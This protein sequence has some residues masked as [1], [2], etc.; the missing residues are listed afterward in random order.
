MVKLPGRKWNSKKL[1][2]RAASQNPGGCYY[3]LAVA[4]RREGG[5]VHHLAPVCAS[6]SLVTAK[7]GLAVREMF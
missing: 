1:T 7:A 6:K 5:A 4:T 2:A 3:V